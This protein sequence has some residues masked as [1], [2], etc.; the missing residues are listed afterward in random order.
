MNR[1]F[2][3]LLVFLSLFPSLSAKQIKLLTIGNS[4]SQDAV[5]QYLYELADA[6]GDTIIIGNMYIGGCSLERHYRNSMSN[7]ADYSY[8]KITDGEKVTSDKYTLKEALENEKWDYVSFQQVSQNSGMYET[9]FPY[10]D[11]LILYVRKHTDNPNLKIIL[12]STWAYSQSS[13]H[14]GF[15]NYNSSQLTMYQ[16]IVE[17]TKQV[18][19]KTNAKFI[20][21]SGTAIQNGRTSS[22]GD[23]FCRDGYHLELTYGRYTAACTWFEKLFGISAIGSKYFPD[24]ITPFQAKIA[25]YAAHYA[26]R[27]PLTITSL[28]NLRE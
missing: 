15:A 21:P 12:H 25:Q 7:S 16:A 20:V 27:N 6:N 9:Y 2:I 24:T 23:T 26:C 5:E 10:I 1:I 28:A 13:T 8:R 19:E 18:A 17:T 14:S 4:F 11:S 22:L 3:N